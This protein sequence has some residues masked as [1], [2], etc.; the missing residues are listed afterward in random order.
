MKNA[1]QDGVRSFLN[2]RTVKKNV[3]GKYGVK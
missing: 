1:V 2:S 3:Y